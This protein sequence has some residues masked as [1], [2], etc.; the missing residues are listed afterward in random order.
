M[1]PSDVGIR[2]AVKA[3]APLARKDRDI[4][5]SEGRHD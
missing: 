3:V 2:R 5:E 1:A 4:N